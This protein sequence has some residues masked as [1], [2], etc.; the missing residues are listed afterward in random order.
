M[1]WRIHCA[2]SWRGGEAR[3]EGTTGMA[4]QADTWFSRDTASSAS[5]RRSRITKSVFRR[6]LQRSGASIDA[7]ALGVSDEA[8][9]FRGFVPMSSLLGHRHDE[10]NQ[11]PMKPGP[12]Y[13]CQGV[14]RYAFLKGSSGRR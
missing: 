4:G 7:D 12:I 10:S 9:D 1:R 13:S 5:P 2:H 8:A 14:P 3:G 6:A 11:C